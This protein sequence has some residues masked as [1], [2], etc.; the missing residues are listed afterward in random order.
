M[1][2]ATP[3]LRVNFR[4]MVQ[5]ISHDNHVP[6]TIV[7]AGKTLNISLPL[8]TERPQLVPD[9]RGEY[10]PY[11]IYGPLVFSRASAL[12]TS[13][14]NSNAAVMGVFGFMG[15]PLVTER[16]A[17]PT[18]EQRELV[19][20]ASPF[21]PSRLAEGYSN[22]TAMVVAT[23]NGVHI[24]SLAHLVG[25]LRDLKDENV[26]FEFAGRN[27]ESLVFPREQMVAAT[28]AILTDNGVRAQ[29]SADMLAVWQGKEGG[30]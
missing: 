4:Y 9:L 8:V 12:F 11:F 6:M 25:V 28:E 15:S 29:G 30:K 2:N 24:R 13:F 19:V 17:M 27:G 23:V 20:V 14:L 26:V 3:D 5:R 22:P 1:V 18:P 21:F 7:R 10:P 16:G